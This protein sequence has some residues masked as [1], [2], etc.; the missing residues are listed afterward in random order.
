MLTRRIW[1]AARENATTISAP[2]ARPDFREIIQESCFVPSGDVHAGLYPYTME[3]SAE[4][5]YVGPKA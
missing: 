4:L 1:G 2:G 3:C 5:G